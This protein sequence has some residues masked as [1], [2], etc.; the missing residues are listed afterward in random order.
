[1]RSLLPRRS[2]SP[3]RRLHPFAQAVPRLRQPVCRVELST[4]PRI[5]TPSD[6][7]E[8][9]GCATAIGIATVT[10]AAIAA[11]V[12]RRSWAALI[13]NLEEKRS[14]EKPFWIE[15]DLTISE[16]PPGCAFM[17]LIATIPSPALPGRR[18]HCTGGLYLQFSQGLS[19]RMW[20]RKFS[21]QVRWHRTDGN[22]R[23]G[24]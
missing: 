21:V 9:A 13:L 3:W 20:H 23:V 19:R 4:V 22:C 2:S 7:C 16:N 15:L 12:L 1:M 11:T 14:L 8:E 5:V 18:S 6:W 10:S 17:C 24:V